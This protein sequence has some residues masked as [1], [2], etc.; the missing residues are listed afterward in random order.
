MGKSA[1]INKG[2]KQL[3]LFTF[4]F[5]SSC[6]SEKKNSQNE[7]SMSLLFKDEKAGQFL[8]NYRDR[9]DVLDRNEIYTAS[10]DT[11]TTVIFSKALYIERKNLIGYLYLEEDIVLIYANPDAK[12]FY[13]FIN[14]KS[15]QRDSITKFPYREQMDELCPFDPVEKKFD[16][17][18]NVEIKDFEGTNIPVLI[19][20]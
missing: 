16:L 19:T 3:F 12:S 18:N 15:L 8:E 17:K 4:L 14:S 2:M 5:F 20:E 9:Y 10:F 11:D 7:S 1:Q 6:I 13:H